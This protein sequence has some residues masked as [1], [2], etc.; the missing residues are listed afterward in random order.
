[1]GLSKNQRIKRFWSISVYV[2]AVTIA[3]INLFIDLPS[4]ATTA[5]IIGAAASGLKFRETP[6]DII[7]NDPV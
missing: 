1:M 6:T 3:L 2:M 7:D 4:W 5:A